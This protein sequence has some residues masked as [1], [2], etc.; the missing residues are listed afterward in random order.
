MQISQSTHC[1]SP[2]TPKDNEK[3]QKQAIFI[4]KGNCT[5]GNREN[6]S[7]QNIYAYMARMSVNDECTS[8]NFG[9]SSHLNN[10]FLDSGFWILEQRTT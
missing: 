5:C 8:G 10:W 1:K 9:K 6:N 2:K 7:D 3:R 4:E